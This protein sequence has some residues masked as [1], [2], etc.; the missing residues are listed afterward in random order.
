MLNSTIVKKIEDFVYAK[1]R[2]VQE[3]AEHL[4]KNWRTADRYIDEI[5]K[6]FGTLATR[7]F[8]EGTRG[9]LK[10]VFWASIEKASHSIFQQKLEQEIEKARRK[11][12]FS[13]FDIFQFID[14][15]KKEVELMGTEEESLENFSEIMLK[16][17]KQLLV[18]SGNLSYLNLKNKKEDLFKAYETLVKKGVSIKILSRVDLD[19]MENIEKALSLNKKYGKELIEIHHDFHPIRA[20][21]VDNKLIRIKEVKEPT[22][23]IKELNKK[24][25]IYYTIKDKSWAEWLSR[26]FWKKW[27][28]SLDSNKRLEE[29]N[30][31]N[32]TKLI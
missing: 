22:G 12:D 11:E 25:F 27:S 19:G 7:V 3:I 31:L 13:A 16:A 23:K 29:L 18:F 5:Q 17:E 30:R 9:A 26:I 21:I 4:G 32:T 1:P 14:K 10:I 15:S 6:E 2:S 20:I 8:R 24:V 28:N